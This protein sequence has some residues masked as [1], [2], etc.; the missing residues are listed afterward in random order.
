VRLNTYWEWGINEAP[1]E[2][3]PGVDAGDAMP[4]TAVSVTAYYAGW[5]AAA[6]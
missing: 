5:K 1:Q 3:G 6:C 4:T 2:L